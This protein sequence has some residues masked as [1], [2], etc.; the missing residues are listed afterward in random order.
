MNK[1]I[2]ITGASKG[3]GK[4]WAKAALSNG[5]KVAATARNLNDLED[6]KSEFGN[7]VL[8]L[9]LDVNDRAACFE[10]VN[11]AHTHFGTLDVLISN[12][13]YGHFG[14]L[15]EISEADA[16]N[17]IETNVFGSL[18]VIQ[19]VL[20]IMRQQN[21]GHILQVSSIG[22]LTAFPSIS[23]YNASKW[24]VEGLCESLSQEVAGMGI[25]VTLIEPGS[26]ATEWGAASSKHSEPLDVYAGFRKAMQERAGTYDMGNPEATA[27]AILTVIEA[28]NPPLRLLLGANLVPLF[29]KVYADR[30]NSWKEWADV[31]TKAQK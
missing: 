26:Y 7:N 20:P 5:Y 28:Q 4:V 11:V 13:G 3:F 2:F 16:R 9:K 25:K 21:S 22:G 29:E 8:T 31:S 15:E 18:W 1:V 24:A 12:A 10:A 19:A 23:I 6:L 17:Q 27:E 14:F 30:L